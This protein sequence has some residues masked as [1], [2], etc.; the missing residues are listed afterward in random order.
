MTDEELVVVG[1]SFAARRLLV[2]LIWAFAVAR[3]H[4]IGRP[5]DAD[6]VALRSY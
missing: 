1:S 2:A 3:Q 4:E 5:S 6:D